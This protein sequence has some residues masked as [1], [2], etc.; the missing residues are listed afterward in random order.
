MKMTLWLGALVALI[1]TNLWSCYRTVDCGVSLT[2]RAVEL[3]HH[4]AALAQLLAIAPVAARAGSSR[5]DVIA[6]ARGGARHDGV[7]EFEKDGFL[8][9]DEIGLRFDADGRLLEVAPAWE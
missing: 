1:A 5:D 9:V 4:E 3:E 7:Q 2:Y 6:A 8:W